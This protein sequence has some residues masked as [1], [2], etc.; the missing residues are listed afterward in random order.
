M[1]VQAVIMPVPR[2][3]YPI[4]FFDDRIRDALFCKAAVVDRPATLAPMMRTSV[5]MA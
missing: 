4:G 3:P 2:G 5:C 1:E